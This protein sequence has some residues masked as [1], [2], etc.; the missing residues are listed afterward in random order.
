MADSQLNIGVRVD[1][2]QAQAGFAR[3]S[4]AA[5]EVAASTVSSMNKM[6]V[7]S[8]GASAAASKLG[9]TMQQV[10]AKANAMAKAQVLNAEASAYM[11]K[12]MMGAAVVG[13]AAFSKM[14]AAARGAQAAFGSAAAA[15][16]RMAQG[17]EGI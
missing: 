7:E 11:A 16:L 15:P 1:A 9:I 4:A 14:Y 12:N 3:V 13:D 5:K 10:V 2:T 6:A 8:G 17:V